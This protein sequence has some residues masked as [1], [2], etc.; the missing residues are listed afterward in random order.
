MGSLFDKLQ[1]ELDDREEEGGITAL[2]LVDLPPP[3]RKLMRILL[4]EVEASRADLEK[5]VQEMPEKDRLSDEDLGKSLD[6]LV[7]QSWLIAL[8]DGENIRYRV[9]LR[10]KKGS[11][12]ASSIWN[13]LEDRIEE[14]AKKPDS[15]EE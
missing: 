3:L 10:R 12:L 2:D 4:R 11:D 14:R 9:N 6:A 8:G 5:K 7:K 13:S 1:N 15:D